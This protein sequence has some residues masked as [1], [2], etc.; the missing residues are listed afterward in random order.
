MTRIIGSRRRL[1]L[2]HRLTRIGQNRPRIRLIVR[3]YL[4]LQRPQLGLHNPRIF[5]G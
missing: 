3:A 1:I 5:A 2:S 4:Q